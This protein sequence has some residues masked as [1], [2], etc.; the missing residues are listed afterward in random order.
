M[1][2]HKH[3]ITALSWLKNKPKAMLNLEAGLGK[4]A[5]AIRTFKPNENILIIVPATLKINWKNEILLWTNIKEEQIKI[6][7]TKKDTLSPG[8]NIINFDLLGRKEKKKVIPNYDFQQFNADRVI[9]DESHLIKTPSAIR[10][11][12]AAKLARQAPNALFLSGTFGER[13]IDLYVPLYTLEL[14][15]K[16]TKHEYG[17]R[18]C[19]G[20]LVRIGRKEV[21]DYRGSSNQQEL[22]KIMEPLIL[23]M[24]K[25]DVI[26]LPPKTISVIELD[27]PRHKREKDYNLDEIL[28][29]PR[30][31]SFVGLAE[32]IHEQALSKLPLAINHIKMRLD[33]S[34]DDT[35]FVIFAR[36]IDVIDALMANLGDYH[37]VKL[38]G[39]NPSIAREK[40]I[41]RFQNDISCR[42]FVGQIKAAGVGITLTAAS[43]V[44]FVEA[45]WSF[46]AISQ[47][48]DR[49]HRIGAKNHVYAEILTTANSID[50]YI[51][52]KTLEKKTFIEDV[53]S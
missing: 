18:F 27:A 10:T 6:I 16:M 52:R 49:C 5:I 41:S 30:P 22:K 3:Q 24:K 1:K 9:I 32:L 44:I 35:K 50:S 25:E 53:L 36:H 20:K 15:G 17:I 45:D 2:L 51:L 31:I 43:N 47:A 48:I 23:T 28:C 42:I 14:L 33:T 7:K 4:T 19:E 39:R 12:I 37:P 29:D 40:A 34:S 8:I 46:S 38:D 26:D 13:P 21:W 11:K